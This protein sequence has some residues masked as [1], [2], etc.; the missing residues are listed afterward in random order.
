MLLAVQT[1]T[2][3]STLRWIPVRLQ[4]STRATAEC[5]LVSTSVPAPEAD[6]RALPPRRPRATATRS[7]KSFFQRSMTALSR[8]GS[9][10]QFSLMP[11]CHLLALIRRVVVMAI[12]GETDTA[13]T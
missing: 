3:A 11:Q 7:E 1:P 5:D 6:R 8:S 13:K 10:F 4:Y 9:A 12:E 2:N